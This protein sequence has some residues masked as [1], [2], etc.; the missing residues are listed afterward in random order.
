MSEFCIDCW[1]QLMEKNDP[2]EK[3]VISR[4]LGLCEGCGEMKP[5]IVAIKKRHIIKEWIIDRR[6]RKNRCK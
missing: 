6:N 1:N 2:P 4:N 5:V 3:Y